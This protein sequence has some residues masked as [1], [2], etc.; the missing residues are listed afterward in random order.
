MAQ[1]PQDYL[2]MVDQRSSANKTHA[3]PQPTP[4]QAPP[5]TP[6]NTAHAR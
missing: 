6:P 1:S 2:N 4:K 5:K 3:K